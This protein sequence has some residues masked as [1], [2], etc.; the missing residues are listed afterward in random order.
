MFYWSNWMVSSVL[1]VILIIMTYRYLIHIMHLTKDMAIVI[2]GLI[3]FVLII[4]IILLVNKYAYNSYSL[5]YLLLIYLLLMITYHD[6][7]ERLIPVK[8]LALGILIGLVL[9]INNPNFKLIEGII[10][11][12]AIGSFLILVS[13]VTKGGVGM[14]DA[15]VFSLISLL[16][17]WELAGG[18]LI[19]AI[20][21]SGIL[22][23]VLF[24]FK[25]V[26]RK[27]TVPFMP[28]V[29]LGTLLMLWI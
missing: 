1:G 10:G 6:L 21:L 8:W 12:V 14:G 18:I 16:I 22:G 24:T 27:S 11:S 23:I 28:F 4:S 7:K 17:G 9:L 20:L 25:K 13:K 29:M 19:F 26:N 15:Y 3:F 5:T 2:T